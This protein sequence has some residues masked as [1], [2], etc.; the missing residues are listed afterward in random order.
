MAKM[1]KILRVACVLG[2]FLIGWFA[3]SVLNLPL[4]RQAPTQWA[5]GIYTGDSPLDLTPGWADNPVLTAEDVTDARATFVA[6]PFL[7]QEN[8]TWYM[9]LEVLNADTEHGDIAYATSTD[10]RDWAYQQIVL[11]EPF[12]VTYPYVFEWQG[13]WYMLPE[14]IEA[15]EVR[16]YKAERFPTE[17]SYAGTLLEGALADSSILFYD[18]VWWLWTSPVEN[19]NYRMRLYY[20]TDLLGTWKEHPASPV[21][22]WDANIARSGGRIIVHDGRIIRFAQDSFP[23]YGL[24]VYAIEVTELTPTSY[25]EQMIGDKALLSRSNRGWN[26]RT[27]H[28]VDPHQTTDGRWIASVDGRGRKRVFALGSR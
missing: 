15:N 4:V 1:K 17:W 14:T 28:H 21:V 25:H 20:S 6:D 12:H 22:D 3:G 26:S 18:D 24:Q 5:I 13:E 2:A 9:F 23:S 16:L 11:D 10:G 19:A 8:G 27:M 7:A